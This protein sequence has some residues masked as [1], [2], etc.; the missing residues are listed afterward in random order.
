MN[1]ISD[2]YSAVLSRRARTIMNN[3]TLV[4][5]LTL[6]LLKGFKASQCL[7][8]VYVLASSHMTY[9]ADPPI[10]LFGNQQTLG[11]L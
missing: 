3:Y 2:S 4:F 1:Q 7:N 5:C 6:S 9:T 10:A 8:K 11:I